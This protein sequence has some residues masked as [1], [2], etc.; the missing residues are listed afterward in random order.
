[1]SQWARQPELSNTKSVFASPFDSWP[2]NQDAPIYFFPIFVLFSSGKTLECPYFKKTNW[3]L[4]EVQ[5]D[6]FSRD[7]F[8][9]KLGIF[10]TDWKVET[11][12]CP[13]PF[14]KRQEKNVK[15]QQP[16]KRHTNVHVCCWWTN[17]NHVVAM[18]FT[19]EY[20]PR[21]HIITLCAVCVECGRDHWVF[22]SSGFWWCFLS[23]RY[24]S[25]VQCTALIKKSA[26]EWRPHHY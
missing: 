14:L 23:P 13:Q 21:S 19:V 2:V 12:E 1:M 6:L 20:H 10:T 11:E 15:R 9:S 8:E 16:S 4:F 25:S 17:A 26:A 22:P 5:F 18:C 3:A 24:R 7:D